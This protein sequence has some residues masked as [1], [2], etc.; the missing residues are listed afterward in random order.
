[1]RQTRD[2]LFIVAVVGDASKRSSSSVVGNAYD[3]GNNYTLHVYTADGRLL[4]TRLFSGATVVA[5][6]R[7]KGEVIFTVSG[8]G[9][10]QAKKLAVR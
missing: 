7:V 6:P 1:V 2:G 9:F 3:R 4:G 10:S 8:Q 5:L